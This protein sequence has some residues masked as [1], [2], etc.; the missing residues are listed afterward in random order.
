MST[1]LNSITVLWTMVE[2]R[3]QPLKRWVH[4]LCDYSGIEDPSHEIMEVLEAGEV[5]KR[6][7][8]FPFS[9]HVSL[10]LEAIDL[11]GFI[12]IARA[13]IHL[14]VSPSS[15]YGYEAWHSIEGGC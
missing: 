11:I 8:E 14:L 7:A 4:L 15:T 13:F 9:F 6:V 1:N 5:T 2:R 3:V 12:F 10:L